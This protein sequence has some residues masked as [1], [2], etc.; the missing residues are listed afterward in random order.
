MGTNLEPQAN[1]QA[2]PTTTEPHGDEPKVPAIDWK[3]E[4]RKWEERAKANSKAAEELE[5]LKASN[6]TDLDAANKR[7]EELEAELA[8][9]KAI[10]ERQKTVN[11]VAAEIGVNAALLSRMSGNT[12]EDIRSNAQ[13]LQ[14]N[15]PIY[16]TVKDGGSATPP[17]I[18]KEQILAIENERERLQAIQNNIELFD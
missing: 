11:E 1:Q 9:L 2:E 3:A 18:T 4:S 7:A 14:S 12:E 8:Q 16:P 17:S 13:F 15:I 6:Q 10:N 5:Q